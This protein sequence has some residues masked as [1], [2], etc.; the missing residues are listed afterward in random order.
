MC[1][2]I[3]PNT[4]LLQNKNHWLLFQNPLSIIQTNAIEDVIPA[5]KEIEERIDH[6]GFAAGFLCYEAAS[7]F[8]KALITYK[9]SNFPLL[10]F[11]IYKAPKTLQSLPAGLQKYQL[12]PWKPDTTS[13]AYRKAIDHI[14]TFLAN[15][16]T[17]QV[18]Y[19]IR[20]HTRFSGEAYGLFRQMTASQKAL[21]NAFVNLEDYAIC[22]AS[23]ELFFLLDGNQLHSCPMKGTAPRGKFLSEDDVLANNLKHSRKNRAE[24]VMIVDMMRNDMGRIAIP[25][26]VHVPALFDVEKYPTILQMTSTVTSQ[27]DATIIDILKALFPC[28]S[29]TG[30]PKPRTM[31]IIRELESSARKIYTGS[32][33]MIAPGRQAFFNVAIRTVLVD[34]RNKTA[35]YGVGGGIVWDSTAEEE[36]RECRIKARVLTEI[37]PDFQLL[38]SLLWTQDSGYY[39]LDYHLKRLKNSADYFNFPIDAVSAENFLEKA[40]GDFKQSPLKVRL[41]LS[42]DGSLDLISERP[43]SSQPVSICLAKTLVNSNNIFL[44]HKTTHRVIYEKALAEKGGADDVILWNERN[45]LTEASSSNIVVRIGKDYWTPPVA[46]GLLPGT[47]RAELLDQGKIKE[48]VI[49]KSQL[50]LVDGIFLINSVRP[51]R[52]A[53]MIKDDF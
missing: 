52:E 27:T 40:T 48:A 22:S 16:D 24:N 5:L 20:M 7:A 49:T 10:W 14:K 26:S 18:N 50:K 3:E 30:A 53:F 34:R 33:G 29:V 13:A 17:Y 46:S 44:Y 38:E 47:R 23:P 28:A 21:N 43:K 45:E 42:E 25:G 9:P 32:I 19:T 8:D 2:L 39:L 36:Y 37:R 31:E 15:G 6:N 11:G 35:E 41:L 51:W 12:G 1:S 4:A